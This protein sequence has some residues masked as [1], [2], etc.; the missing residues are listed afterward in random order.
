M[1]D[2]FYNEKMGTEQEAQ[3]RQ[4]KDVTNSSYKLQI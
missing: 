1:N 3:L 4:G 2:S